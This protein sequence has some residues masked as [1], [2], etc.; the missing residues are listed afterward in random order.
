MGGGGGRKQR[1]PCPCVGRRALM[2]LTPPLPSPQKD[3]PARLRSHVDDRYAARVRVPGAPEPRWPPSGHDASTDGPAPWGPRRKPHTPRQPPGSGHTVWAVGRWTSLTGAS[4]ADPPTY[5]N[6]AFE[7]T[8]EAASLLTP[9]DFSRKFELNS[10]CELAAIPCE[11]RGS[12]CCTESSQGSW[13]V[14]TK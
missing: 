2:A 3:T 5:S 9:E 14:H 13:R 12:C 4:T 7:L 1:F 8:R 11:V 6:S 10:G